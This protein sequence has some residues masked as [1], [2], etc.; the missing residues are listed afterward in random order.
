M[1]N[2]EIV[3]MVASGII[4]LLKLVTKIQFLFALN[5]FCIILVSQ[6]SS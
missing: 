5:I 6:C 4:Q 1:L 3:D 2:A